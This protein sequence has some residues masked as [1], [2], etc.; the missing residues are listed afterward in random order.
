VQ[1][2][3]NYV[4]AL[5]HGWEAARGIPFIAAIDS[6]N[7]RNA[8]GEGTRE[9]QAAG[10]IA[11]AAKTGSAA[12]ALEPPISFHRRRKKMES[13]GALELF[14]HAEGPD[15]PVLVKAGLV[16]VRFKT[17]HP[18]LDGNGRMGRLL[19]V[20]MLCAAGVLREPILYP[21]LYFKTHR[22]RHYELLDRVRTTGD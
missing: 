2:V 6:G 17:I 13:M 12:R 15:L 18:F 4:A 8:A 19:I 5:N 16:H 14:L 20:F 1:E 10:R 11:A 22:Q 7:S 21:S 9:R 3:S